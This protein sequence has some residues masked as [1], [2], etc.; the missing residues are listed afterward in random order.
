MVI[1][2]P[3]IALKYNLTDNELVFTALMLFLSRTEGKKTTFN[4]YS[5]DVKTILGHLVPGKETSRRPFI[6]EEY[7]RGSYERLD[8]LRKIFNVGM[9]NHQTWSFAFKK[10][11]S[12]EYL[13]EQGYIK[14]EETVITD[15]TAIKTYCY[16]VGLVSN[17]TIVSKK[18][19]HLYDTHDK[20][21]KNMH[22]F[23]AKDFNLL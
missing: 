19:A 22:T 3:E 21:Q 6:P 13:T 12:Y 20:K 23:F 4:F 17:G 15:H 5:D 14:A 16:I 18:K 8:N 2:V 7:G 11:I 9:K 1:K 10:S